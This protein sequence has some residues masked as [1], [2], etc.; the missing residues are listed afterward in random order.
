M[1]K[2]IPPSLRTE[3]ERPQG[4]DG[5]VWLL[6]LTLDRGTVTTPPVIARLC[7]GNAELQW[8][9]GDPETT[10]WYPFPFTFSPVEETSEGDLTQVQVSIDNSTRLL[11]RWLHAGGGFEGNPA[12]LFLVPRSGLSIA[13]PAHEFE[14]IELQVMA[15]GAT[16][17]VV[18][19]RL[20]SPNWFNLSSP[21]ER[22][23]PNCKHEYGSPECGYVLN[24]FAA[25]PTCPKT[26]D[27]CAERGEDMVA[28]GL[29]A[30]LPGNFGGK[31]GLSRQR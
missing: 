28:R 6:E 4:G 12:K 30:I 2:Q 1:A 23:L 21:S 13:Y 10:T 11:M 18:T 17:E 3:F 25:F 22:H 9:L 31:I 29:P 7:D 8:P 26:I 5:S 15:C 20:G 14:S 27:A 16:D 24:S 19:L